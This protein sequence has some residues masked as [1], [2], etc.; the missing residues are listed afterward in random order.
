M[1]YLKNNKWLGAF[2]AWTCGAIIVFALF[3]SDQEER[4]DLMIYNGLFLPLFFLCFTALTGWIRR[5]GLLFFF[6]IATPPALIEAS[7]FLLD[8]STLI[9]NQFY[10]V[11][12]THPVEASGMLSLI[13]W[14]QWALLACYVI[15]ELTLLIAAWRESDRTTRYGWSVIGVAGMMILCII[16]GIRY[17][18]PCINFY[19][20][21]RGYQAELAEAESFLQN[22]QDL[23]G[24]V[25]SE[26]PDDTT[27]IVVVIGESL[28]KKHCSLYG[29]P[30]PTNPRL[31]RRNDLTC[32]RQITSADFMTQTV[33]QQ[34]VTFAD[35]DHPDARWTT[36]TLP[37]LLNAAGWRTYWYEKYEGRRNTSH[38]IPTSFSAI[39]RLCSVYQVPDETG[40]FDE[41]H[42][43]HLE[44]ALHDTTSAHKAIFLHLIGN[45]FPYE[46][47]YPESFRFF[48]DSDICSPYLHSLNAQQKAVINAYDDAV[49]Y[50]DYIIDSILN[51]LSKHPGSCAMLYFSDHGEEVYDL[52][53]YAGR[54]YNHI[55]QSLYEI[56]CIYWQNDSFAQSHSLYL[57]P[58]RPYCTDKMMHSLLDLFSV[59][60]YLKDSSRSL[61]HRPEA[62]D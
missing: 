53:N 57:D 3:L 62:A 7:W 45:H 1:R 33:L 60:Y 29:Y 58:D 41:N 47:R 25:I 18:V 10:A 28:T 19:N 23:S 9:R 46:R 4:Q 36:P 30:R 17:N 39:A 24:Q 40:R 26:E 16:P 14:W 49:R 35:T 34:V 12:A 61:F 8:G 21:Y 51:R 6:L 59:S 43:S 44:E 37:E 20:S 2:L 38:T 27:T 54:S 32:F 11:Y 50:N 48:N 15:I 42:W 52:D 22:R 31:Q 56:P 55:T 13:Q 5:T